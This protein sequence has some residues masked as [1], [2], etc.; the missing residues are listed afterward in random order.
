[1]QL[2]RYIF[3]KISLGASLAVLVSSQAFPHHSISEFDRSKIV[4]AEGELVE[5]SWRN[6]HV[7]FKLRVIDATGVEKILQ[8]ES[9]SLSILSRTNASKVDLKI[10]EKLKVAG[11]PTRRPS[12]DLYLQNLL[13]VDRRECRKHATR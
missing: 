8:F 11:W 3:I 2:L 1:M 10:G 5:V 12:D 9:N 13:R 6:P 4:E 7:R